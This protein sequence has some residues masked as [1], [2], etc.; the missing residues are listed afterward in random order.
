MTGKRQGEQK[1][2]DERLGE[3]SDCRETGG[4]ER[5]TGERHRGRRVKLRNDAGA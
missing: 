5:M 2:A 1:G 3:Q 4:A